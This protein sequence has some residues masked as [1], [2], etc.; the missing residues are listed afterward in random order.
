[1]NRSGSLSFGFDVPRFPLPTGFDLAASSPSEVVEVRPA[2]LF[3]FLD[4]ALVD[5]RVQVR[6]E[7]A[8]MDLFLVVRF[9][10]FLDREAVGFVL[11]GN[12]VQEVALEACQVVHQSTVW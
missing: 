12:R 11:A 7:P 10:F 4:E 3:S 1:M 8:V 9:E 5:E 2:V 6:V